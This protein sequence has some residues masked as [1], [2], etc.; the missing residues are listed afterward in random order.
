[1]PELQRHGRGDAGGHRGKLISQPLR[2]AIIHIALRLGRTPREFLAS[3]DA[4]E[5]AELLVFE[6]LEWWERRIKE[7]RLTPEDKAK[8]L[9]AALAGGKAGKADGKGRRITG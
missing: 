8:A 4:M 3:V 6:Q 1:M 2:Q 9:F 5:L 7:K